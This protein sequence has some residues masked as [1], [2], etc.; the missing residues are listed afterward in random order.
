MT[1]S[2]PDAPAGAGKAWFW[3]LIAVA[4]V[5]GVLF[6]NGQKMAA[7]GER[8]LPPAGGKG[9]EPQAANMRVLDVEA[10]GWQARI[11]GYGEADSRYQLALASQVSGQVVSVTEAFAS[12]QR[13]RKNDVLLAL[14]DTSYRQAL[15]AAD[16]AVADARVTLLEEQREADQARAEWSASGLKGEPDSP[17]RLREPQLAAARAAL[18]NAEAQQASA[19]RDLE[20]TRIR[21]PFDAVITST[22]VS[23][24][25]YLQ[26]GAEVVTLM[27]T[28]RV[29]IRLVLSARE[30]QMLPDLSASNA[31]PVSLKA[32]DGAGEWQ[33]QILRMEQ[34]LDTD[35]RQRALVVGIDRPLDQQPVLL[36]GTFVA[37]TLAGRQVDG[38]WRLPASALSQKGFVWYVS[39]QDGH[40]VLANFS[41]EPV[42]ADASYIYIAPPAV[43]KAGR[44]Q[45]VVQPLSSYSVGMR[46][47]PEVIRQEAQP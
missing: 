45:V 22:A 2:R 46:V 34:H 12:G 1:P 21:A 9:A 19:R 27:S 39:E 31:W 5:A 3:L 26:S 7:R 35:T 14:D 44:Q 6:W 47:A 17:L 4:F 20:Q 16:Q 10:S 36:P 13:V 25:S 28:D 41:A 29:E 8:G 18:A 23:P 15:A 24:G 30:W 40:Q 11:A 42:F 32:V 43:L 38:L 37:V 33:G